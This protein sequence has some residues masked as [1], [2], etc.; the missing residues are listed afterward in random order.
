MVNTTEAL[1]RIIQGGM[2][3]G[4]SNWRLARA[5]SQNG[6]LGVISGTCIDS[7]LIRR[8]QDGDPGGHLRRAMAEFPFQHA[9][10]V[11][12][13]KYFM[14]D[15]RPAGTP[16][17]L[18]PM[19]RRN[20]S[21]AR[22]QLTMLASFVE[23]FLAKEGHD[24]EIG[25][26][27]LT[28]VQLPNLAT[29]YGAMLAGVDYVIMGAGIPREIPGALDAF[30][31]GARATMK[32]EMEGLARGESETLEFDPA[33]HWQGTAPSLRRPAFLPVVAAN[34]L[35]T[36]LLRKAN[37]RID[38]FVVEGPTAGGH[39]APPRG[40]AEL[41]ERGEPIYG[42][43]DIVDLAAMRQ[44]EVPFWL[45]GGMGTSDRLE[46]ALEAGAAGIQVGTLFAYAEESGLDSA[47]K[48]RVLEQ[49]R[50][51][52]VNVKTDPIAS[53]TGFPFKVVELA[54]T[55]ADDLMYEART[56]ICDLGYLR[57]AYRRTDGT[58]GYRCAS[59]PIDAFVAKGGTATEA[60]GRKCLCNGLM[61]NIGHA[62]MRSDG[63]ERPLLTSGDDLR[64]MAGFTNG[65][66]Q[67]STRDVIDYL[68]R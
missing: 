47:L 30:A 58:I 24:G 33:V 12:L 29:L 27:L 44:L 40:Q 23:V 61:A 36:M 53:P 63:P 1:P 26:N 62:Q 68:L 31:E 16:Y 49:V 10:A 54:A 2:G 21:I 67:Y 11:T 38:G 17:R 52:A 34:S 65:R 19:W 20:V 60:L 48:H 8:L 39:N 43:R 35:A 28:K 18:L 15:E 6:Q 13:R 14:P 37:G 41:N 64:H 3:V 9:A 46:A 51:G 32:F 50:A 45:A 7:V 25:I 5:V 4:V 55:N 22:E 42:Q 56:R 59:E 66:L 57:I